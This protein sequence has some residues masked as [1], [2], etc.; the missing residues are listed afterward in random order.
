MGKHLAGNGADYEAPRRRSALSLVGIALGIAAVIAIAGVFATSLLKHES[1]MQVL[2]QSVAPDPQTLFG[3]DRILVLMVGRDYDYNDKDEETSKNSRSDVIM[4]FS[5]DFVHHLINE[6][7]VP[8]DMDVILNGHDQ[9]INQAMSDGGIPQAESVIAKFLGTPPFDRWIALR[10]NSSKSFVD[11]V[12]GIE[13]PVKENMDYDDT[14]GHLHIHFKAG[15]TYHMNGE[16]AV[17]YARF[18]H[19]A[20]GDPCRIDRQQQVLHI[21]AN[22]LKNN[23]FNDLTHAAAL[24]SVIKKNIDS[25][26]SS[27]EL[28]SLAGA[29][30]NIDPKSM[31]T[32]QVK[33]IDTKDTPYGGNVLVA[34]DAQKQKIVTKLLLEPPV[35]GTAAPSDLA[36]I[37]PSSIRIDVK[38]GSGIAGLAHKVA[39]ALR[40]QGYV[41]AD[42]GNAVDS[43]KEATEI[44]EHTLITFAGAKV[45]SSFPSHTKSI[46]VTSDPASSPAP[47]SDVTIIVGKDLAHVTLGQQMSSIK[48]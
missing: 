13:V 22:T 7:S 17:S 19:D 14:W 12:G 44:H 21:L 46:S 23:K 48:P 45:R 10:I 15:K 41:I 25:N 2:T 28:I 32:D 30:Q 38:N 26:L 5:L 29:F 33:Y 40:K 1:P 24:I 9:K 16:Q 39:D 11:A 18:R 37:A 20:C 31:K 34:D 8:R 43:A 6:V 4:V 42:V 36:A 27:T 47:A 3:K 35:S